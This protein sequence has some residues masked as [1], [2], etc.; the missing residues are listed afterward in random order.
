MSCTRH[1]H[2]AFHVLVSVSPETKP[3]R[4]VGGRSHGLRLCNYLGCRRAAPCG[5]STACVSACLRPSPPAGRQRT[6]GCCRAL[7]QGMLL[8]AG[9]CLQVIH[10]IYFC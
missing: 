9:T 5:T 10:F 4:G 2:M 3:G 7:R 1:L 6:A 8:S